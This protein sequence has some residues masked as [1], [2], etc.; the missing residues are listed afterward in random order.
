MG[1]AQ[2]LVDGG[3][4]AVLLIPPL[5]DDVAADVAETLRKTIAQRRRPLSPTALLRT[6][7]RVKGLVAAA[8]PPD[9]GP[10]PVLDVVL[11]LRATDRG[12]HDTTTER[13]S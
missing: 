8:L 13:S 3:A 12:E 6:Q 7:A 11:F 9:A 1:C 2:D 5:P 4:N 10:G